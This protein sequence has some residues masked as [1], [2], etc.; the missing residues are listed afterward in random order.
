MAK[1]Q[2][3]LYVSKATVVYCP[4]SGQPVAKDINQSTDEKRLTNG[5]QKSI[6]S[7]LPMAPAFSPTYDSRRKLMSI[8]RAEE[9]QPSSSN[10]IV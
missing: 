8:F 9:G 5:Q 1:K 6:E 2:Q 10:T 4:Q 7:A 3:P